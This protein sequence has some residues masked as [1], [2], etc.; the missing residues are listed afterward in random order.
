MLLIYTCQLQSGTQL[1]LGVAWEFN[2]PHPGTLRSERYLLVAL[3]LPALQSRGHMQQWW[4][5]PA[6]PLPSITLRLWN[7]L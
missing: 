4:Q 3:R 2:S 7:Y 6:S 5:V 1:P